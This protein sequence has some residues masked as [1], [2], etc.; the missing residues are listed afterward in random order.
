MK[1]EPFRGIRL[2]IILLLLFVIIVTVGMFYFIYLYNN[3][4]KTDVEQLGNM[5]AATLTI[6]GISMALIISVLSIL[7]FYKEKKQEI[8][9]EMIE[10][11]Q[12]STDKEKELLSKLIYIQTNKS[13]YMLGLQLN[14]LFEIGDEIYNSEIKFRSRFLYITCSLLE[15]LIDNC[16]ESGLTPKEVYNKIIFFSKS[17]IDDNTIA[18][19][20]KMDAIFIYVNANY[21][22]FRD[23]LE[24][25][26]DIT[27][28]DNLNS[29]INCLEQSRLL[30]PSTDT[31]I[32]S[33]QLN[34]IGLVYYWKF[35]YL[36]ANGEYETIKKENLI[37]KAVSSFEDAVVKNS[38]NEQ[39]YNNYGCSL[40][41]FGKYYAFLNNESLSNENYNQAIYQF[42][43]A[44]GILGTYEKPYINLIDIC[45]LKIR[46]ILKLTNPIYLLRPLILSDEDF[47][48]KVEEQITIGEGYVKQVKQLGKLLYN[49]YY[50]IA[51]LETY[52]LLLS[53]RENSTNVNEIKDTIEDYLLKS[54]EDKKTIKSLKKKRQFFEL[55]GDYENMKKVNFEIMNLDHKNAE[56]WSRLINEQ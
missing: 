37:N 8:Q 4:Q 52:K 56:E 1:K 48:E 53:L 22:I 29:A 30:V 14:Y 13:R 20:E 23:E 34:L 18:H 5:Q 6:T 27:N 45:C 17:I 10:T 54:D 40:I 41:G 24:K 31:K 26:P 36:F 21:R 44:L 43:K 49:V 50:K 11:N 51:E 42:N 9:N 16:T 2:I 33:T 28:I 38:G 25:N 47:D 46:L 12:L 15:T 39:I 55:C 3:S 35:N 32:T 19:Y 7:A